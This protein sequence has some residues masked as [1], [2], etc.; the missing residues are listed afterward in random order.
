MT[1]L[2]ET[3][4]KRFEPVIAKVKPDLSAEECHEVAEKLWYTAEFFANANLREDV[5][6]VEEISIAQSLALANGDVVGYCNSLRAKRT[7]SAE[8][9]KARLIEKLHKQASAMGLTIEVKGE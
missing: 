2:P 3:V 1:K 5:H 9:R 4:A 8:T 7:L 6:V